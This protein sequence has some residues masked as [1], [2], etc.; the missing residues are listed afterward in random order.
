[1]ITEKDFPS[2]NHTSEKK[3][4]QEAP[5]KFLASRVEDVI[6]LSPM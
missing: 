3:M 6:A 5:L 4:D 2:R 1:M